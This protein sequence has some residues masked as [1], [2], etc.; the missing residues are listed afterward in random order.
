MLVKLLYP[1]HMLQ[2]GEAVLHPKFSG[3]PALSLSFI[4]LTRKN[5]GKLNVS[6]N[7][8]FL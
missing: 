8:F 7:I 6:N 1:K 4:S 3:T 5:Y 2:M